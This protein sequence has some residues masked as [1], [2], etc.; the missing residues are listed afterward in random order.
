MARKEL[1]YY[2]KNQNQ[3]GLP[4]DNREN[5]TKLDWITWTATL[6]QN[7]DDFDALITPV[8]AFINQTADRS[9]LTDW[10]QTKDAKKVGFTARPVVGGVFAQLLY[11]QKTWRK[12]A[13]RDLTKAT[14]WAAMP[15]PPVITEV[16]AVATT[17]PSEWF[18]TTAKP[19]A[20][21]H[22]SGFDP[23]DWKRGNSGFGTADTPGTTVRTVWSN[24]DIWLVRD[25]ELSQ[26]EAEQLHWLIHHDEETEIYLNGELSERFSG[27]TV[28]YE[29]R[30]LSKLSKSLLKLGKNRIA[31]HCHQTGGGQYIDVGLAT[32]K[33]Q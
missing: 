26:V 21:W 18:Y 4:L 12:W 3:F 13:G 15:K 8:I 5:Y 17:K 32:I 30:P 2:R 10:Y 11:D 19:P 7:R 33:K 23:K 1:A 27:Y 31:V 9:P 24:S 25:V 14:N 29:T 20:D 22:Q 16:V 28:Q 6:T